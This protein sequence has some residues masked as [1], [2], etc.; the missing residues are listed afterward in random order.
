[1]K[2]KVSTVLDEE[3][4]TAAKAMAAQKGK[5]LAEIIEEALIEYLRRW[6]GRGM[7]AKTQGALKAPFQSCT[8]HPRRG[9]GHL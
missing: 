7:V 3:L 6:S 8:S 5:R 2:K 4:L 9:G 1:M